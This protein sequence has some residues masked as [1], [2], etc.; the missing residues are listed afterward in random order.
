MQHGT[1]QVL[2]ECVLEFYLQET[3]LDA[4]ARLEVVDIVVRGG[5]FVEFTALR[6]L[7][8]LT[9]WHMQHAWGDDTDEYMVVFLLPSIAAPTAAADATMIMHTSVD[10]GKATTKMQSIESGLLLSS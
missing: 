2:D 9:L 3:P 5:R 4:L 6:S 10:Q 1:L 7:K 8:H